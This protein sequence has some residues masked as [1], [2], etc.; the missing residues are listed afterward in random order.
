MVNTTPSANLYNL[1]LLNSAI[2]RRKFSQLTKT[3]INDKQKSQ[4]AVRI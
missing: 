3:T 2:F 4:L 1:F